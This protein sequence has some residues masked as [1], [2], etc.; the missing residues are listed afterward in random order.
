M[1]PSTASDPGDLTLAST[2]E[3]QAPGRFL[4]RVP[5]GWQQG[6]GAFGGLVFAALTRAML[7]SEPERDR[8]LRSFNAELA[9]PVMP[10]DAL[11]EVTEVRRGSGLSSYSATLSQQ[12][13]SLARASSV[14]ARARNADPPR[15]HVSPPSPP[16][17]P[18]VAP[19]NMEGLGPA[20]PVFAR[21][22]EMRPMGSLPFTSGDREPVAT[23][24]VRPR[25][26]LSALG[27][28][29]IVALAD[30]W[31]PAVLATSPTPRPI[32]TV[33]FSLQHFPPAPPLDPSVPLFYRGRVLA[34]QDG[35]MA[36]H[37]E[38]WTAD[39]RLV[40]L[41]QQTIAWIR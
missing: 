17:W 35:Y 28:P 7:A 29:E 1:T 32:G 11:V 5:E 16:P 38:L 4:L 26:L 33:A 25:T 21:H 15:L 34:E 19:V 6:R 41:N 14:L 22:L 10:G 39:G 31:W 3:Q 30:A 40:A 13:Q 2:P 23:G 18:D 37:R 24:W 20:V 27:A 36:E 8:Q 12:G 9:G